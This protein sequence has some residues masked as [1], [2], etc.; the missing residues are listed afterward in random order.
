LILYALD[1]K[2]PMFVQ[3]CART[4]RTATSVPTTARR[5]FWASNE[6]IALEKGKISS[7]CAC[8]VPFFANISLNLYYS[9][10]GMSPLDLD[11]FVFASCC[12]M[13]MHADTHSPTTT[14]VPLWVW[15]DSA[16]RMRN[17]F[18]CA[19]RVYV[20]PQTHAHTTTHHSHICLWQAAVIEKLWCAE[21]SWI[22]LPFTVLCASR[23][24][25]STGMLGL[26]TDLSQFVTDCG[27]W[28][29]YDQPD[30]DK[31]VVK[32]LWRV[33]ITAS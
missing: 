22:N 3:V 26:V 21:H 7:A 20:S 1:M 29:N 19:M 28:C 6:A 10:C 25:L 18:A 8:V 9:A 14:H 16:C 24:P 33:F 32:K 17:A 11:V 23:G 30:Y 31:S 2:L 5:R 15:F 27:A 4:S 12:D 13:P